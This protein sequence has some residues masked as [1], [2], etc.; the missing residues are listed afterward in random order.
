MPVSVNICG[1]ITPMAGASG[2]GGV[3]PLP[4]ND[5][6]LLI[7]SSSIASGAATAA[8]ATAA[9]TA[10]GTMCG[11]GSPVN[12][13]GG[14]GGGGGRVLVTGGGHHGRGGHA[15]GHASR[16]SSTGPIRDGNTN[17]SDCCEHRDPRNSQSRYITHW[18]DSLLV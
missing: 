18:T 10:S 15:G 17:M 4:G 9:S 13:G 1:A 14:G 6:P 16:E 8:T 12:C 3:I 7:N 5:F 11:G 2:G